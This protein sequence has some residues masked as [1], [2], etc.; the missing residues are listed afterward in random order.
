MKITRSILDIDSLSKDKIKCKYVLDCHYVPV[1]NE[2]AKHWD[3][4]YTSDNG[5]TEELMFWVDPSVGIGP[6]QLIKRE[7]YDDLNDDNKREIIDSGEID[8]Y[9]ERDRIVVEFSGSRLNG[10]YILK[11]ENG[12]YLMYRDTSEWTEQLDSQE[13]LGI[14]VQVDKLNIP[15]R[16]ISCHLLTSNGKEPVVLRVISDDLSRD[17]L[18]KYSSGEKYLLIKLLRGVVIEA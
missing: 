13:K 14:W 12:L 10:K 2:P 18:K 17:I 4:K 8:F 5:V 1:E 6:F 15:N 16:E 9:K 11:K 7:H 3:I